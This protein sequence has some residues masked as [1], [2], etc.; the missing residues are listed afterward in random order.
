MSF[1]HMPVLQMLSWGAERLS[2]L[3]PAVA[4]RKSSC[5]LILSQAAAMLHGQ[6]PQLSLERR[7]H[8]TA[9]S[10]CLYWQAAIA[11]PCARML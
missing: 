3:L 7:P 1:G 9:L 6:G 5:P 11:A 4:P 10:M 2:G 8:T